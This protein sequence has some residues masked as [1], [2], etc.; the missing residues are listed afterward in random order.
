LA[1]NIETAKRIL[2]RKFYKMYFSFQEY[3]LLKRDHESLKLEF[4]GIKQQI[5]IK[6]KLL[7]VSEILQGES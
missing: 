7:K 4:D 3:D 2:K 5:E 1:N 6:D